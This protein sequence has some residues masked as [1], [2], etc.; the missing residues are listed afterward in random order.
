M[1]FVAFARGA[2]ARAAE[3]DGIVRGAGPQRERT[4]HI[5]VIGWLFVIGTM[6]LALSS[7]FAAVAFFLFAGLAPVALVLWLL[8]RRRRRW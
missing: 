5:V 2:E 7:P 4:V 6:A 3:R 1:E 8:A